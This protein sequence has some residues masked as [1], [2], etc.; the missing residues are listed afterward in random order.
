MIKFD[1]FDITQAYAY[2]NGQWT[3]CHSRELR[4]LQ[5][6]SEKEL[7]IA[8]AELKKLNQLQNKQFND[9]TAKKLAQFFSC[10]EMEEAALTPAWRQAKKAIQAQRQKDTELKQV[11]AQIEGQL[12]KPDKDGLLTIDTPIV[13]AA[14]TLTVQPTETFKP[15]VDDIDLDETFKPLEEW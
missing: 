12:I 7:M 9:I 11:H 14:E 15:E 13:I 10:I 4:E 5:G 1:P 2:V 6:H 8:A 3:K